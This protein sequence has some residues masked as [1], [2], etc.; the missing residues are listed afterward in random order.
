[1][2][3]EHGPLHAGSD[4]PALRLWSLA[5]WQRLCDR[6]ADA[7]A[8]RGVGALAAWAAE[9]GAEP[10]PSK[11]RQDQLDACVCLLTAAHLAERQPCLMV[12]DMESG[13][14]LVPAGAVFAARG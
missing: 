3:D 12:G 5:D 8:A 6:L 13:C 14:M 7:W 10:R 2:S 11:A 9:A 4:D 1:M